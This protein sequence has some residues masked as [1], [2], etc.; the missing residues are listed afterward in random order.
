VVR[1]IP[2]PDASALQALVDALYRRTQDDF[3]ALGIEVI[4]FDV[5]KATRNYAELKP[6]QHD[7]PWLTSTVDSQSVFMAPSGMPLYLD[8]PARA[9]ALSAIGFS[10]GTNTRMK[11]VMM[12]YDLKQEVH[13]V[14]VNAVVD[15]ATVSATGGYFSRAKASGDWLHHLHANNTSYRFVSTTQPEL[16]VIRLKSPLVSDRSLWRDFQTATERSGG[17]DG[18]TTTTTTETTG[19]G[20]FDA[21]LYLERSRAMLDASRRMFTAEMRKMRQG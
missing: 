1:Q 18:T 20:L 5:L 19:G 4:P 9:D 7:A 16:T 13:L 8:N 3:T 12:T 2:A 15:F 17:S 11:E 14:S 10:F 6:A 21:P